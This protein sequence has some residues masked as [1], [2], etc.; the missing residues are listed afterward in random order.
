MIALVGGHDA[1]WAELLLGAA[2]DYGALGLGFDEARSLLTLGRA[3][4]RFKRWLAARRALE[5]ATA[6]FTAFGCVGWADQSRAEL[7]RVGAR[8][9][10]AEGALTTTEERV[11]RLAADGLSN[12]E[13]AAELFVTVN[14]VEKHLSHA[15][16]KLGVRSRRHL[17]QQLPAR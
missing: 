4:R 6:V 8:R 5:R 17:A 2:D 1:A 10:A 7:E 11:A 12:K 9:P 14:T 15:Y 13:I 16:A 3:Q